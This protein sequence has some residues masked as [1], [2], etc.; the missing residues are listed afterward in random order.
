[1][2]SVRELWR[3]PVKS[4]RGER[5][6]ETV[7]TEAGFTGDRLVRPQSLS[8]RRISARQYPGLLG[9]DGTTGADGT[10]LVNGHPWSSEEAQALVRA[11]SSDDIRLIED[12]SRIRFDVLPV[13][14]VTD[15]AL[16][17]LGVDLRRLRPNI[18]IEGID[19]LAERGW[20]GVSL[21]VG[22]AVVGMRQV[23]GRCVMTTFDPD[24][25]EQDHGVLRRIV[26][27]FDG[28]F[29]L[30]CYV[31]EPGRIAVGDRFERARAVDTR[32]DAA[33]RQLGGMVRSASA[34]ARLS[35]GAW[36]GAPPRGGPTC[37]PARPGSRGVP[38][39]GCAE[40][41]RSRRRAGCRSRRSSSALEVRS[42]MRVTHDA[43][44]R[45]VDSARRRLVVLVLDDVELLAVEQDAVAVR[46]ALA[47]ASEIALRR[48]SPDRCGR[49]AARGL[50]G[51]ERL[52]VRRR[53]DAVQVEAG[54]VRVIAARAGSSAASPSA[55]PRPIGTL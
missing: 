14:L 9:L 15:G 12:R 43:D 5:V 2:A 45:S 38:G 11:A 46:D 52:A 29:A 34:P 40:A 26:D 18:V 3:Y 4:M 49:A 31:I 1:M 50:H 20:H 47:A 32:R 6:E 48:R 54:D 19:G 51:D 39:F 23:R 55:P 35:G 27:E 22:D 37:G 13:S 8:G 21:R 24:T 44:A 36:A 53:V 7:L 41:A 17:E 16:A 10:P 30:D 28:R 33:R 42:T 25:L